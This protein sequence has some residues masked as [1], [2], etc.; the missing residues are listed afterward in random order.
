MACTAAAYTAV[1]GMPARQAGEDFYFL[2]K[3]AKLAPI[4]DVR[5]T[6]VH[7]SARPSGRVPFGT[8]RRM[9]RF[10]AGG[11]D[12]Y[13]A[14]DPGVFSLLKAWLEAFAGEPGSSGAELLA[15]AAA[16][17]PQLHSFLD[18]HEFA[19]VWERIRSANRRPEYLMRQ[20]HC[21]FDGFKTL[22]L[23]HE[24][25][26]DVLPP[27]H[28]FKALKILL[29]QMNIPLA[30]IPAGAAG[31]T[32]EEQLLFLDLLRNGSFSDP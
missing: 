29:R 26:A 15:R 10:L 9:L 1:R 31:K 6:T 30:G 18:R 27:L 8:G 17:S 19:A 12:E 24:L 14:Y 7:P 11:H 23:I 32:L 2:N 20:F 22:K 5:D 13:L 25:S 16:L 21:W 3:L 4:G 28:M